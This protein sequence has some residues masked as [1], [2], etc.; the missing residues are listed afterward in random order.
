MMGCR[1]GIL[2]VPGGDNVSLSGTRRYWITGIRPKARF[3]NLVKIVT[4]VKTG[5][6]YFL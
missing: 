5:V 4:P 2:S 6:Q 1:K 3:G